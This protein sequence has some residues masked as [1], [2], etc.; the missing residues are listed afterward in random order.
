MR[1]QKEYV[2]LLSSYYLTMEGGPLNR[3]ASIY[4]LVHYLHTHKQEYEQL[5]KHLAPDR[6]E[7]LATSLSRMVPYGKLVDA[8]FQSPEPVRAFFRPARRAVS[9][10]LC[11][12]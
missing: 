4:G 8:V 7:Q 6:A 2:H 10:S 11:A 9:L 3:R 12:V 5:Y 1:S